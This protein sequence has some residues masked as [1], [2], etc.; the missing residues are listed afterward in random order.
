MTG[1]RGGIAVLLLTL[2]GACSFDDDDPGTFSGPVLQRTALSSS[3]L[4]RAYANPTMARRTTV[5]YDGTV[6]RFR[7]GQSVCPTPGD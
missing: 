3:L 6:W 7:K 1:C 2:L 4:A 5:S